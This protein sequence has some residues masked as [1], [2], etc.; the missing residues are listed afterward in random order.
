MEGWR[1]GRREA[2]WQASKQ[3]SNRFLRLRND[4]FQNLQAQLKFMH[5]K[6]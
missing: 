5:A 2:G 3:G 6:T 1:E 4:G